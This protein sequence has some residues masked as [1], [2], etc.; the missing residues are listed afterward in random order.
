MVPGKGRGRGGRGE[1]APAVGAQG[2]VKAIRV[3]P[4]YVT[5]KALCRREEGGGVQLQARILVHIRVEALSCRDGYI[6]GERE[7]R[8]RIGDDNMWPQTS[9][10]PRGTGEGYGQPGAGGGEGARQGVGERRENGKGQRKGT[11]RVELE[12]QH[13]PAPRQRDAVARA[14]ATML[15]VRMA[16]IRSGDGVVGSVVGRSCGG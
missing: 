8:N 14:A 12:R 13:V 16:A 11:K 7:P 15:H 1:V 9:L 2:D 5:G 4:L 10:E 6:R 3:L